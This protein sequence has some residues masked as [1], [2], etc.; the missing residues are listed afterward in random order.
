MIVFHEQVIRALAAIAG[1][2]ETYADHIRRHLDHD[3]MLPGF[4]GLPGQRSRVVSTERTPRTC[5]TR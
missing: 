5:G 1:Y 2:T 4:E 3:D